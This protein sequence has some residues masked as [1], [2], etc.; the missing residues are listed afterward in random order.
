MFTFLFSC[1]LLVFGYF[2]YSKFV[3]NIFGVDGNR[4][5][6]SQTS[7]DGFDFVELPTWKSFLIQFL[8]IAG[9]G[10]IFGAIAGAMWGANAFL[11]I[12]FGCVF[13]GAVHDYLVGMMSVRSNGTTVAELVGQNI[14][15]FAKQVM[16]VLSGVLLLLVG[17]VFIASPSDILANLTGV[18]RWVFVGIILVYYLLAT[19]LPVDKIIGRIYP[20]FGIALLVMA[21]GIVGGL[22]FTGLFTQIPEFDFSNPHVASKSIFPYLFISIA[23]GAISGFHA[24]QS[25][26]IARCIKSETEGRRVFYGAMITEGFVALIWAAAAMTFFGG[27]EGLAGAGSAPVVVNKVSMGLMGNIGMILAVLGVVACPITSGDTAFRALRLTIADALKI[28]QKKNINRYIIVVPVFAIAAALLFIDFAIIWRYFSWSNQTLATFA[29]WAAAAYLKRHGR[30]YIVAL[31]PA[32]FMTVV[33]TSYI[34]VAPEGFYSL[35]TS[36]VDL[37]TAEM[38]GTG[39][40]IALAIVLAILFNLRIKGPNLQGDA[41]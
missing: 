22:V 24:T 21:A 19:V 33:V 18:N 40:G 17:V 35:M 32:M 30:S 38:L 8:N 37:H 28:D 2:V 27:L 41:A 6:P 26:I 4:P 14:N 16:I 12:A 3:A 39:V 9:T 25:P 20:I 1:A 36:F 11:W 13:A 23:C 15:G 7:A 10:P 29:L 34:L 31:I 5:V